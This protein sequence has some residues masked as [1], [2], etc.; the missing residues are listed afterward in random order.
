MLSKLEKYKENMNSPMCLLASG[1][2]PSVS[3][4]DEDI[5]ELKFRNCQI[6]IVRYGYQ[7]QQNVEIPQRLGLL[8]AAKLARARSCAERG[9]IDEVHDFFE[10]TKRTDTS[11]D[12]VLEWWSASSK[13]FPLLSRLA[14][15]TFMVMGSSVPLESAFSDS[16]SFVTPRRS[17]SQLVERLWKQVTSLSLQASVG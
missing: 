13:R 3:V 17:T 11:C 4:P 6:L 9:Q 7:Q 1:L 8:A 14:R 2:D 10:L 12:N 15:D 5:Q 16:G